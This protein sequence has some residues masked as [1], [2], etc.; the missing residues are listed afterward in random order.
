MERET[1][2][3]EL[4]RITKNHQEGNP[5]KRRT[6]KNQKKVIPPK[7]PIRN[8]K[9]LDKENYTANVDFDINLEVVDHNTFDRNVPCNT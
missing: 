2:R 5:N 3:E 7:R 1:F 6:I 8:P 4:A 9:Q